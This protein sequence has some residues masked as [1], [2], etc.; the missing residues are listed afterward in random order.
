MK[1]K[2]SYVKSEQ[3][4]ITEMVVK[5]F[6]NYYLTGGT[7]LAFYFEHRFS[8]D[9]DFFTQEYRKEEPDRIMSFISQETGFDFKL[10]I[11]QKDP[12]LVP[13]KVYFLELEH[14]CVLKIDFVR[15]F[16]SNIKKVKDGLHAIED[17]YVRKLEAVVGAGKKE[18]VVGK[19]I[20]VGRQTTKDLFD[21]YYLSENYKKVSDFFLEY[22]SVDRVE[23]F[24]AWYRGFH[25]MNLKLELLDLVMGVDT[26]RVLKHLDDEILRNLPD[27]LR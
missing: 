16:M 12:M 23:N 22:F 14:K 17:I 2:I 8:E 10:E 7:A 20:A 13:M 24:I 27:K 3:K 6:K 18:S 1:K 25:R 9:L 21:I 5:K 15:D 26:G 19:R 4:K 11:E